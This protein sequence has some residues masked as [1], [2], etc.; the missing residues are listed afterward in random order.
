MEFDNC[1]ICQENI[2]ENKNILTTECNHKFHTT[3]YLNYVR[4]SNNYNCP[5]CRVKTCSETLDE[6]YDEFVNDD[7]SLNPAYRI[8]FLENLIINLEMKH[9]YECQ[10]HTL[11]IEKLRHVKLKSNTYIKKLLRKKK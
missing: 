11:E 8:N 3:C 5:I 9:S 2:I 7:L 1:A 4:Y 6:E 10:L